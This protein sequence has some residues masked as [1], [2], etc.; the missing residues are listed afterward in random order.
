MYTISKYT[1]Q[2]DTRLTSRIFPTNL[3]ERSPST[4]VFCIVKFM[5]S[6][7]I[8]MTFTTGSCLILSFQGEWKCYWE[9]TDLRYMEKWVLILRAGPN[10]YMVSDNPNVSLGIVDCKLYTRCI[11]LKGDYHK[12]RRDMLAYAPVEYNFM[13]TLAKPFIIPSSKFQFIQENFFNNAPI[14]WIAIAMN[15]EYKLRF[16]WFFH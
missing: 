10:F 4:K 9:V 2:L 7:R 3:R 14:R 16:H 6:K 8:L 13:E 12:K 1:T 5:T 15:H 11:G